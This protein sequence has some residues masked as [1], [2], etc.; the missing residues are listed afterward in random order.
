MSFEGHGYNYQAKEVTDCLRAGKTES[1]IMSLDESLL[2]METTDQIR[3][4]WGLKYPG[5]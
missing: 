4:Q 1:D 5:E 3:E 2:I